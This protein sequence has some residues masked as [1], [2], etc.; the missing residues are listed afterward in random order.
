MMFIIAAHRKWK[1]NIW[2]L[3]TTHE[4]Y[5]GHKFQ[6]QP[7]LDIGHE[8]YFT[9]NAPMEGFKTSQKIANQAEGG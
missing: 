5:Y 6:A 3:A 2:M 7:L 4:Q 1:D 8:S 9:E